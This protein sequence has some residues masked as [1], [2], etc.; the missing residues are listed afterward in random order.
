MAK[1]KRGPKPKTAA[2]SKRKTA[3]GIWSDVAPCREMSDGARDEFHR[4][5]EVLRRAGTLERSELSHVVSLASITDL[6]DRVYL[7]LGR[8]ELTSVTES[9][10]GAMGIKAHPLLSQINA[11]TMRQ[12]TLLTALGLTPASAKLTNVTTEDDTASD[13]PIRKF[14]TFG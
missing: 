13:D 5:V 2:N 11:L 6:L 3:A 1:P 14:V 9:G 4:L 8:G 12:T 7:E 10:S